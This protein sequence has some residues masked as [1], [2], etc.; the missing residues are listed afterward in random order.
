MTQRALALI[1]GA[2][3]AAALITAPAMAQKKPVERAVEKVPPAVAAAVTDG[4]RPPDDVK[5]DPDRKPAETIAFAG[6]KDGMKVGE[7]FPGGG[8]YT[9]MLSKVVGNRGKIYMLTP[10]SFQAKQQAAQDELAKMLGNAVVLFQPGA[11]P[12]PPEP[13]DVMW[14]TDNYHDYFNPG[15]GS[16]DMAQFNK[17]VF[18]SLKPGGEYIIV[19]YVAAPGAGTTQTGTLHRIDEDVVK[20]QV[21]AAGF[22]LEAE[23]QILRSQM[24]DHTL[25]IFDPMIR[26]KADQFVLKFRKPK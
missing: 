26:G 3:L 14:S 19:D 20:Q 22:K 17:S 8:Y 16:L 2:G 21:E 24:D 11:S 25:K 23:S 1:V 9:R 5:R 7:L 6:V 18:D 12:K 13:V 4:S 15:F 10:D